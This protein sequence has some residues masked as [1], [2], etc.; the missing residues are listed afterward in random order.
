[1]GKVAIILTYCIF[2]LS[3]AAALIYE[4]VWTRYL[5]LV[6]GGSHLAVTT[7]LTVLMAGLA[8]GSYCIGRRVDRYRQLLR[9]F[10][11][12]EL[13][14]GIAGLLFAGLISIYTP[15]YVKLAQLAPESPAY[16]STIRITFAVIALIIPTTLMGGTLPV[17]TA[18]STRL[19]KGAGVRLSFLYGCNTIGAVC[20]AAVTGFV[21][22][23]SFSMSRTLATA[24]AINIFVALVA[25]ALQR[26][27][28]TSPPEELLLKADEDEIPVGDEGRLPFR[29][30]LWGIG[31]SGFCAMGYE[32]LWNRILSI[33][34]GA[35]AYGFTLLLMAFL[36]GIGF[37][38]AAFGLFARLYIR[39][40]RKSFPLAGAMSCF[41]GVQLLIGVTA[42]LATTQFRY[43]PTYVAFLHDYFLNLFPH[44]DQFQV[45]Q[46]ANFVL[47]FSLMFIPACFMGVAFPLAG[48]I[49]CRYRKLTGFAVGE[50]LSFNTVG[51]ILG[52]GVS[53]Y[54]LIYLFESK[55]RT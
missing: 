10:G 17:L 23:R 32:V 44:G 2:F 47:A 18:F 49:H 27:L 13:G 9:L 28:T 45:V 34:I 11:M 50:L 19:M 4:I 3:G 15:I 29:L 35:S 51:A 31:V 37:G 6:F 14:V 42:L 26:M 21:M 16:L 52:A 30:V 39:L 33:A 12:L 54:L 7:V 53:G 8:L 38:S 55:F 43:L 1:M 5:C 41:G 46:L 36:S 22:L 25:F 20:G 48:E 40:S 24:V